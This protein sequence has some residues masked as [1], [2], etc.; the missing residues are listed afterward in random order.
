MQTYFPLDIS[1]EALKARV[2]KEFFAPFDYE[3][4]GKIDFCISYRYDTESLHF[5]WAEAKKGKSDIYASFVQLILTIGKADLYEDMLPPAF[6][7]AFDCEKIAFIQYH[8]IMSIFSQ[9]DFNWNVAPSDY[10]TKEFKQL[11]AKIKSLLESKSL[12]FDFGQDRAEL[13]NF[14]AT[15][16]TLSNKNLSKIPITKNNFIAIYT[17]W[18]ACVKPSISIDWEAEKPEILDSDFYLADLL[19]YDNTTK[20]IYE[21]LR[22]LLDKDHYRIALEKLKSGRLNISEVFFKDSQ[23]AHSKFWN[24]YERPP[25]E[26]FW[27]YIIKRRDLLVPQD[28]RERKGAFFTPQ[29]WVQKAQDYLALALGED[30]QEEYY[31]WDCAAGTGN[32]LANLSDKYKIYASTIDKAD[33]DIMKERIQNGANL[34][35]E[36]IFAFDFLNDEL[37]DTVDKNGKI[38]AESK[39]PKSLQHIIKNT[40]QKLVIFINPPYAEA[41]SGKT[42]AGTGK[43]KAKVARENMI[44]ERYKDELGKANN[45]LFAQFFM[46]IYKEIS[47]CILGSFSTLKY[48]NS[49]NF[50]KFRETFQAKFLKGFICPAYSFDN[51]KGQF[52]IGF[53]V[54]NLGDKKEIK[55]I[56]VDIFNDSN[57]KIGKKKLQANPKESINKWIKQFDNKSAESN[58]DK[59]LGYL[60]NPSPDFQ[61][62]NQM[63]ISQKKGIEHFNF[64]VMSA[65]NFAVG[66]V[67]FAVRQAIK[68]SWINDRDQFLYPNKKWQQDTEFHNDCLA[69]ALFHSQNRIS[70]HIERSE[71]SQNKNNRDTSLASQAQYDNNSGFIN[72]FIP[73]SEKEVGAKSAFA[74][75]FI[76]RFINGKIKIDSQK[77]QDSLNLYKQSRDF[78]PTKPLAFSKEAQAVFNAGREI[79][80]YYHATASDKKSPQSLAN[81]YAPYN[82]NASLYDIKE[83]FKGRKISEKEGENGKNKKG[84]LNATSKDE[85][86]N[87]LMS[88]LNVALANL[89][90]KIEPKIY[91]YKFLME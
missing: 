1:E 57:K 75:D 2:A 38:I 72:H 34:C 55:K 62:N 67:Y 82:P 87:A 21:N 86:F 33:I 13:E 64:W 78:I 68:A 83:F 89:A 32:L 3:P 69:F 20:A 81:P 39:L 63:Y 6:L 19:S 18:L 14:I 52:P 22:I 59:F 11:H 17:K 23:K 50:I 53:L 74:S 25:K 51:V 10:T 47:N 45:E 27:D 30:W 48:V 44:C 24:I 61:H 29:I 40:P 42:P 4:F 26:E 90:Q 37:F 49:T 8:E 79:W 46:R 91:E 71:I 36:H 41:T 35:E 77:S 60:C 28:I 70:C 66:C 16:F 65:K 43:N 54:W 85:Y 7:G 56:K 73:F 76:V 80:R 31:I 58:K 15:N 84:K 9:N 5:L 12:I 88:S